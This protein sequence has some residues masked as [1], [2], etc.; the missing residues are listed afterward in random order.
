MKH[1]FKFD[2]K[3][4]TVKPSVE[5]EFQTDI[6]ECKST[7]ETSKPVFS[8]AKTVS[9]KGP[10]RERLSKSVVKMQRTDRPTPIQLINEVGLPEAY[11]DSIS[12]GIM[13]F[14][15]REDYDICQIADEKTGKVLG[16][17]GGYALQFNFNMDELN[18]MERIEQFLQG[19]M[20]LFR[21]KIMTHNL[22]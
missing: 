19:L 21:H 4:G 9:A 22:H 8:S 17:I 18:S 16:F 20:K 15:E 2:E 1:S 13:M 6:E 3:T 7:P 10:G 11:L 12:S 5:K 14:R